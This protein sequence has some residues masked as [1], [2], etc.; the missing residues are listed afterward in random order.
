MPRRRTL[1][2][3]PHLALRRAVQAHGR[4][5]EPEPAGDAAPAGGSQDDEEAGRRE[6]AKPR[7]R[8]EG[9]KFA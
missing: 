6:P 3:P 9:G 1:I 8:G 5:G 4:I 7:K 2:E